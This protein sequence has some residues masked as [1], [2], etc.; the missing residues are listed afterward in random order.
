MLGAEA[1]AV[2]AMRLMGL[3][4]FWRVAPDESS[5]MVMEKPASFAAATS[6]AMAAATAGK[7]ADK[8]MA[9]AITPLRKK[10]SANARRLSKGGIRFVPFT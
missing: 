2:I 7:R 3:S 9:A 8:V 1:Q 10:T 6:A 4:G 5:R